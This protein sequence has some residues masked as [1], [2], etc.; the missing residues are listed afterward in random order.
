[1]GPA[2]EAHGS[3]VDTF[4]LILLCCHRALSS[5]ERVSLVSRHIA[6]LTTGEIAARLLTSEHAVAKRLVRARQKI[7]ASRM[8]FELPVDE[9]MDGRLGDVR[10]II[11]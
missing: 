10:A 8:S 1:M 3:D 2:T 7:R 9:E 6:G 5:E 4:A 11:Y